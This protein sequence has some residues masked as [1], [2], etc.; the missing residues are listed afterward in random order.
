MSQR[1]ATLPAKGASR[2][3]RV[4]VRGL[5]QGVGFRPFVHR[6]ATE[7]GLVGWVI[8]DGDGVRVEVEGA[9]P[10]LE[11][12]RRRIRAEAPPRATV[13]E[14]AESW[15]DPVGFHRFEIRV[16]EASARPTVPVLPDA[17]PCPDCLAEV[18]GEGDRRAGYPF[19]N[20]THCGPRFSIVRALPYDRPNTTL[21][22]FAMCPS[23][24][25]EYEDPGDR[26]FHAQPTAC[27]ACGPKTALWS[28]AG[29]TLAEDAEAIAGAASALRRAGIVALKGLGG[30]QLLVDARDDAAVTRLRER[31]HRF[32]KP[33]ALL[34]RDLDA[35]RAIVEV[36]Q[37]AA[38]ALVSV[39]TPIVLLRRRDGAGVAPAVAPRNPYLGVMLP[40]TPL[41]HLLLREI[42]FPVVCTSG[43]L[44]DE[45][46]CIDEGEALRRLGGIADLFLVH[47]RPIAR[48]VDDSV[49]WVSGGTTRLLRR[50]RGFAPAP[51][52][53]RS[54]VPPV[55][56]VGAHQKNTVALSV[57]D[58][59]FVSQHVGDLETSEAVEAFERVV[60]D[61]L[62][63]YETRPV[64][65]AH[66]L[67]PDYVST[68]WAR[69]AAAAGALAGVPTLAVQHHHAHLAACLAE[70]GVDGPALG[71]TWDGTGYG[72]DGTV[73]GGEFLLGDATGC[74]RVAHLRPFLLPGG[75]AAVREP[76]RTALS[77]L[78]E[79]LGES[80][81]DRDDLAPLRAF[82]PAD[83]RL[84]VSMLELGVRSPETTSAGRLFDG[85]AA[86][87]GIRQTASFEGQAAMELEFAAGGADGAYPMPVEDGDPCVLDWRP[88]V[89]A[90]LGDLR[91][92][93]GRAA[94]AARFHGA[95][96]A[97]IVEVARRAGCGRVA[98]AGGCFQNR[99]LTEAA[100]SR[101]RREGFEVVLHRQVPPNDGSISLGQAAV[102]A[103]RLGSGV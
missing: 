30:F 99:T 6:L 37:E 29:E 72:D 36:P 102:A 97:A 88:T 20:C 56:A 22:G 101:L 74:R 19:T 76:R 85:I 52:R 2:R 82:T 16:S 53:L 80:A 41:H 15:L 7:I 69:E 11:S 13:H 61:F 83:A 8:N 93:E 51:V 54:A 38:A 73:W 17:A 67:H 39:E 1:T 84:L 90:V 87:L 48:H 91:R 63:L 62:E 57:G 23:C 94:V 78:F 44:S 66:D 60:A 21:A 12:F 42:D 14:V 24:R 95:L 77:L 32:E 65:I 68:R 18:L 46:I 89:E 70:T 34:V 5:V 103:A 47:D 79:T 55:L 96:V 26:R 3:L 43:N 45:P 71:V 59:V 98:L 64:A 49:A 100:A 81:A 35:A 25:A 27:P 4:E 86:I 9:K 92:G 75:E 28:P 50:A 10:R 33:F 58:R 40:A 31:K